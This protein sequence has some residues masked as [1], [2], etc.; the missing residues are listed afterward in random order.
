M[1]RALNSL[2]IYF[3]LLGIVIL[4]ISAYGWIHIFWLNDFTEN[5][6][7]ATNIMNQNNEIALFISTYVFG[8]IPFWGILPLV[9]FGI[10]F[11][12][13][14]FT[15]S[16]FFE[17]KTK[18]L[19]ILLGIIILL[20]IPA[21]F[22]NHYLISFQER[23]LSQ[24][25]KEFR[26]NYFF[27]NINTNRSFI[28][29]A[30]NSIISSNIDG[31][32]KKLIKSVH[33][34]LIGSNLKFNK[35]HSISPNAKYFIQDNKIINIE[36]SETIFEFCKFDAPCLDLQSLCKWKKD[37]RYLACLYNIK[38]TSP[39]S[40]SVS[41]RRALA[42]IDISMQTF[43]IIYDDAGGRKTSFSW[44]EDIDN[45]LYDY[46]EQIYSIEN[47]E[48]NDYNRIQL[49][50]LEPCS[51]VAY[52]LEGEIYCVVNS[53]KVG[54]EF[55]SNRFVWKGDGDIIISQNLFNDEIKV[56]GLAP[57]IPIEYLEVLD[58][59]YLIFNSGNFE[60]GN[61]FLEISSGK[62]REVYSPNNTDSLVNNIYYNKDV[63]YW[64][65]ISK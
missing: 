45:F 5:V 25:E 61:Y 56:I 22:F 29:I 13:I 43:Q 44:A 46:G 6:A 42:I 23:L 58:N 26:E 14:Y 65:T 39:N 2:L 64:P 19:L 34:N 17:T 4:Y 28:Y 54:L 35:S 16:R 20:I 55:D 57:I 31:T 47:I 11:G 12:I 27:E 41:S 32:N 1:K 60:Y 53:D 24:Q 30:E 7:A 51:T 59:N 48:N 63:I 50:N 15:T 21:L 38:S 52:N 9:P 40:M 37:E 62:L 36:T 8:I 18:I 10:V 49:T 33:P 3:I